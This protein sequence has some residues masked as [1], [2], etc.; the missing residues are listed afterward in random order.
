MQYWN[1]T[2]AFP[3]LTVA[4]SD[5]ASRPIRRGFALSENSNK[6]HAQSGYADALKDEGEQY[7]SETVDYKALGAN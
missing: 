2:T 4:P 6:A 7:A 3:I 1:P 5:I